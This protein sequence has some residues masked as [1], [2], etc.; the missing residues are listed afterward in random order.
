M[1]K[2]SMNP[3]HYQYDD[4]QKL[5][6]HIVSFQPMNP[7]GKKKQMMMMQMMKK[8]KKEKQKGEDGKMD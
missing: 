2:Q 3:I 7:E 1:D 6:F 4:H 8:K 5:D